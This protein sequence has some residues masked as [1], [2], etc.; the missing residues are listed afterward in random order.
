M[1]TY[2]GIHLARNYL[3]SFFEADFTVM[4]AACRVSRFVF[5]PGDQISPDFRS[6]RIQDIFYVDIRG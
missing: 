1:Q 3:L 4:R 6:K 2:N 5:I